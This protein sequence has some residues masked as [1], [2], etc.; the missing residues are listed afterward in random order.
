M[1]WRPGKKHV[2]IMISVIITCVILMLIYYVIFNGGKITTAISSLLGI[3][4][5]IITGCVIAYILTPVLNFIEQRWL[6]PIYKAKGKD[7]TSQQFRKEKKTVRKISVLMT[8][9]FLFLI[10]YGLLM[11]LIPQLIKSINEIIRNFPSYISNLQHFID[12]Y[13]ND[14]PSVRTVVDNLIVNYSSTIT[15]MFR[16]K[17]VPNITTVI[18]TVSKSMMSVIQIFFYLVVGVIVAIYVLNSKETFIGQ[19]KKFCYAFFRKETANEII[20]AARYAHHTFTGFVIGKLVDSLIIG[21]ITFVFCKI[22]S[23]PYPVLLAF[24]VGITNIIPFF[25]PYIGAFFGGIL[26]IMINPIKA[27]AF[28]V[29]IVIIQ[30]FDGNILGPMILGNSTGLSSFWVIFA[31]MFFGGVFGPVGW[32]IGVPTFACIYAFAGYVIRKKLRERKLPRDTSTYID[33]AF[34][35]DDGITSIKD[36]D[37]SRYYVHNEASTLRRMFKVYKKGKKYITNVVPNLPG[38][39]INA[40]DV[41]KDQEEQSDHEDNIES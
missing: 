8:I 12:K 2:S 41:K 10:L 13:L 5:P 36:A 20:G 38:E 27:L 31:I 15:E 37:N 29:L 21:I 9:A 3:M 7:L 40:P 19:C 11:V 6:F 4:T 30:Q 33:A 17:I 16:S 32:L 24:V 28:I 14:N 25:G 23:I 35:D 22:L 34:I 18:Q 26:L 1:K 39:D